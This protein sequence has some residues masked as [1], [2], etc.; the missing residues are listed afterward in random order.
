MKV[1]LG[2]A[3]LFCAPCE[4]IVD[5]LPPVDNLCIDPPYEF[6]TSGGGAFRSE[7]PMMDNI[8]ADGLDKGFDF[9]IINGLLYRSAVVFCH[10][11]Q[12]HKLLPHIAGNF[13]RYAVC[14]WEKTNP[15][16]VANRHYVPNIEPY[17]HAWNR[18][19]HPIGELSDKRRTVKTNNGRSEFDHPT[20]KPPEVMDKIMRN[21]NGESVLDCFMGTGSTGVSAIKHGK[22]FIGIEKNKKYFDIAVERIKKAV[23]E[24]K[25]TGKMIA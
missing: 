17:I 24:Q 16:P 13:S 10:N 7:R 11:D 12:L 25:A 14:F 5:Q 22:R 8:A 3:V 4:E 15:M 18:G 23:D 19:G 2:L 21:I 20:V 9:Q 1:D 6:K